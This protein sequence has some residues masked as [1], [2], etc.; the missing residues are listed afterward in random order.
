MVCCT[1]CKRHGK[2]V[3]EIKCSSS[4]KDKTISEGHSSCEFLTFQE[5]KIIW[6]ENHKYCT[7]INSQIVLSNSSGVDTLLFGQTKIF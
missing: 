2:S 1:Y 3:V 7:Q 6:K 5:G 4:I